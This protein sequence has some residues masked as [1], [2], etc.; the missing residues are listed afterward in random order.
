M[1]RAFKTFLHH[2]DDPARCHRPRRCIP[3]LPELASCLE[4]RV[5]LSAAGGKAHAAEVAQNPA[6]TKAGKEVINLFES[7][8]QTNPSGAQ[9]TRLVRE[10]RSGLSVAALRKDLTAEAR[11]QQGAW[12]LPSMNAVVINGHTPANATTRT[13]SAA[14][15][16]LNPAATMPSLSALTGSIVSPINAPRVPLGMSISFSFGAATTHSA[17]SSFGGTA[18]GS[19]SGTMGS[20]T[21]M[22][23]TSTTTGMGSTSTTTGMGSTTGM[24]MSSTGS[25]VSTSMSTMSGMSSW[26]GM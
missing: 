7:I 16:T 9:L 10:M 19:M 12:A 24:S 23:S 5:L 13:R 21:G 15:G 17:S 2:A 11:A 25:M 1:L 6:D 3:S 18:G 26:M 20:T 22:G 8:L 14:T 4:D